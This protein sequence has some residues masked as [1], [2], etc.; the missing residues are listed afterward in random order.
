MHVAGYI[1]GRFV[2]IYPKV[3]LGDQLYREVVGK[4]FNIRIRM[5]LL[6]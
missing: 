3:V 1:R 6:Q 4:Y 5:Y 2:Y